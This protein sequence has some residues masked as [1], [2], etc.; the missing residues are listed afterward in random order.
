MFLQWGFD[1]KGIVLVF[2][3]TRIREVDFT[4]QDVYTVYVE[5]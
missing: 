1:E 4:R 5:C 3:S 2:C